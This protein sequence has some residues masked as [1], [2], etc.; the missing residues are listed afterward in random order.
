[1][2]WVWLLTV[3]FAQE[4]S[5]AEEPVVPEPVVEPAEEPT[6]VDDGLT[7]EEAFYEEIVVFG[8]QEVAEARSAVVRSMNEL[9]WRV[10]RREDGGVVLRGPEPWMGKAILTSTGDMDWT[11]PVFAGRAPKDA[12]GEYDVDEILDR[13]P[14][15]GTVGI[16]STP[17]P[18]GRK[19]QAVRAG[20]MQEIEP[21]MLAYRSAIQ[22]RAL[23]QSI[24]SLPDRL[25]VLWA[26]GQTLDGGERLPTEQARKDYVLDYWASRADSPEGRAVMRTV[27]TW[28]QYTVQE[29]GTP[30]TRSEAAAAEARRTDGARLDLTYP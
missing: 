2:W 5:K 23:S 21:E 16:Q 9:G 29:S 14:T 11:T 20:L 4:A 25:D 19:V 13:V 24:Q 1:M 7:D 27:R 3:S 10:V 30:V 22:K 6:Q 17:F 28:L 26:T 8:E 15:T 12:G 18:G